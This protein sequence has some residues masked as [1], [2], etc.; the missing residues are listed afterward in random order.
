MF[1][2]LVVTSLQSIYSPIYVFFTV[3]V[4]KLHV[5]PKPFSSLS[6]YFLLVRL[7]RHI[8]CNG[9]EHDCDLF[10][11]WND[12]LVNILPKSYRGRCPLT[13]L[14][15][16]GLTKFHD[17]RLC[18]E[19]HTHDNTGLLNHFVVYHCLSYPWA[20]K[21]CNAMQAGDHDGSKHVLFKANE[22]IK[23]KKW[24]T[25]QGKSILAKRHASI[26][27]RRKKI[28]TNKRKT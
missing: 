7:V 26:R 13:K 14:G 6:H 18:Q 25:V 20:N 21:L 28:T 8:I 11:Q 27:K 22:P 23:A 24:L 12:T 5:C 4:P 15:V 17:I 9:S 10:S 2:A 1:P 16:F 19:E 3:L